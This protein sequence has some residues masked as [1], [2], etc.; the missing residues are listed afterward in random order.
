MKCRCVVAVEPSARLFVSC[1]YA[2]SPQGQ[3]V[4]FQVQLH[5]AEVIN[6][7]MADEVATFKK[8]YSELAA[9]VNTAKVRMADQWGCPSCLLCN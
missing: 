4:Q 5:H 8:N 3:D 2:V 7:E 6:K 1:L 9:A